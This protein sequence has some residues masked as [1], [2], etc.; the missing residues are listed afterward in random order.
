MPARG[1]IVKLGDMK[2]P[3][4]FDMTLFECAP[5]HKLAAPEVHTY[6]LEQDGEHVIEIWKNGARIE[7]D[8][9]EA[10]QVQA[11]IRQRLVEWQITMRD[12]F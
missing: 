7:L 12:T 2:C 9:V 5:L 11:D 1:A 4:H 6:G 10:N 3:H 8:T